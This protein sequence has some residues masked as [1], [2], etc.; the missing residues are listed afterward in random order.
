VL[1]GIEDQVG[2]TTDY[3]LS[4]QT[5]GKLVDVV[6]KRL[7]VEPVRSAQSGDPC[8]AG[9][10]QDQDLANTYAKLLFNAVRDQLISKGIRPATDPLVTG[11]YGSQGFGIEACS[12]E[13][14]SGKCPNDSFLS[15]NDVSAQFVTADGTQLII[16]AIAHPWYDRGV[17]DPEYVMSPQFARMDNLSRASSELAT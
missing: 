8:L 14:A 12:D 4:D 16:G 6:E 1:A 13:I 2:Q 9:R 5:S 15:D 11:I 3:P 17:P 7:P 10:P